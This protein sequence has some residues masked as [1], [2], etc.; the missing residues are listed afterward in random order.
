[1]IVDL[2][3]QELKDEIAYSYDPTQI[4]KTATEMIDLYNKTELDF[5]DARI[6]MTVGKGYQKAAQI[7]FE[8]G[9]ID[10]SCNVLRLAGE[11]IQIDES[12]SLF[13]LDKF[14]LKSKPAVFV[15][16][17][18][19]TIRRRNLRIAEK[20][21]ENDSY[22]EF[23]FDLS[24]QARKQLEQKILLDSSL[25]LSIKDY[26]A[27]KKNFVNGSY[28]K[29]E[30]KSLGNAYAIQF[31]GYEI[32]VGNSNELFNT[33]HHVRIRVKKEDHNIQNL[34]MSL[35]HIGLP[36][37]LLESEN[38]FIRKEA[39]GRILAF[40]YPH[41][42]YRVGWKDKTRK[43]SETI[44]NSL[45]LQ[46]KY[47]VDRDLKNIE[48][49]RV[50]PSE[51]ELVNP[52]LAEEAWKAGGRG[53]I[54]FIN[55]GDSVRDTAQTLGYILQG[56]FLSTQERESRGIVGVGCLTG[57]NYM[58][59][60]GA[61][62][63]IYTRPVTKSYFENKISMKS[64][65]ITGPIMIML[66][67]QAFE[68]MPYSYM[69]D[70]AGMRN[71]DVS[72]PIYAP[73]MQ[74]PSF[75]IKGYEVL[76]EERC[77]FKEIFIQ[78]N[79]NHF[80]T[81]ETIF[82]NTLGPK[83]IKKIVVW[84]EEVKFETCDVLEKMG[85]HHINGMPLKDVIIVSD[86]LHP[87]MIDN[88]YSKNPYLDVAV[89]AKSQEILNEISEEIPGFGMI[90]TLEGEGPKLGEESFANLRM[91]S[92]V[93]ETFEWKLKLIKTAEQTI[94][95]SPN[96]A[97]GAGFREILF[98]IEQQM[99]LKPS[100]KVHL[101]CSAEFLEDQDK[102]Y[103]SYLQCSH[104][105]NFTLLITAANSFS[106][107][108]HIKL[109]VVD[110]KYFILG[111]SSITDAQRREIVLP[112][113]DQYTGIVNEFLPKSYR[114]S[115][116]VGEGVI[117]ERMRVEFFKLFNIWEIR[118]HSHTRTEY[119]P[120]GEERGTNEEFHQAEG[121]HQQAK[122]KFFVGGPE[123]GK[124]NPITQAYLRLINTANMN[125][126][127]ANSQFRPDSRIVEALKNKME[128]VVIMGQFNHDHIL[129]KY[130]SRVNYD[131]FH[132]IGEYSKDSS[133]YHKKIMTVDNQRLII[134]SYNM[135][136]KSAHFDYEI[137]LEVDDKGCAKDV[138]KE[139]DNDLEYS[140]K[141]E[142]KDEITM[143]I[144][145]AYGNSIGFFAEKVT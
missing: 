64:F 111:G 18:D 9:M 114:D 16:K 32:L 12:N 68:R 117:A 42:A 123:H 5:R 94:E 86:H 85:I 75:N 10:E 47:T 3:H 40:R 39:L 132:Y 77:G 89:N 83:Y 126:R 11:K 21:I 95:I 71:P 20:K 82:E 137:A 125:I 25:N 33:Y 144:E 69:Q 28:F 143:Q 116:V 53:L 37:I 70:R 81:A 62:T 43:D 6:Q 133:Y 58:D 108:N 92:D 31:K 102:V 46:Q 24:K 120:V 110:G 38:D 121:L 103:L 1:M 30:G 101:I 93:K 129:V 105:R 34:H 7:Y 90:D 131:C 98:T 72:V 55:G 115:D 17:G 84:D 41:L 2:M 48:Y 100:L 61:K 99:K 74:M 26:L 79:Q 36:N 118:T 142:K 54:S 109:L 59:W 104:S 112:E 13:S 141:Y 67:N 135:S 130:P 91:V 44:Y 136:Q 122:V 88:F 29:E 8:N 76:A 145:R 140:V 124:N 19:D 119:F 138:I 23:S 57:I 66:D 35:C 127:V 73:E 51:F 49:V 80:S 96:Y 15:K 45:T 27:N 139:L 106:T 97:G 52:K 107:D 56:G 4:C 60:G 128:E 78:H 65:A 113:D 14:N 134:G 63:A 22:F 50:A 87:G